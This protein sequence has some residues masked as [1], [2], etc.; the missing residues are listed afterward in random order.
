MPA[1]FRT[2]TIGGKDRIPD[3]YVKLPPEKFAPKKK[4]DGG[5]DL[6]SEAQK[7][8]LNSAW[9]LYAEIRGK[10]LNAVGLVLSF[11]RLTWGISVYFPVVLHA[12]GQRLTCKPHLDCGVNQ[13]CHNF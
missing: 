5:K 2:K 3:S 8:Q 4:G 9:E 10:N 1:T 7:L 12:G 6:P 13:R 11:G